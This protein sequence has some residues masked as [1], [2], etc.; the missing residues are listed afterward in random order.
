[1]SMRRW[2]LSRRDLLFMSGTLMPERDDREHTA[3]LIQEDES[4]IEAMLDDE[5]LFR[6]LMSEEE[7][8]VLISP[9]LFFTV[10]LRRARR[11]LEQEVFTV[12]RRS[13]QKVPVFDADQV[14]R[15]LEQEPLLDYLAGMLASFTRV[16]SVTVP[17]RVRRGVWRKIRISDLDVDSLM[18]YCQ[19]QDEKFHFEPYKRIADVCLFLTGMFPQYIHAQ[20]RYPLSRQLRPQVRSRM[21]RNVEDYEAYGRAF[22]RLAA[23]HERARVE[24]LD[25]VLATLSANFIL[26]EKP[27]IFLADRYLG[28]AKQRLFEL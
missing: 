28:F 22:Y 11:D 21:C 16:E 17:I 23:E 5:R 12:E 20:Y 25:D 10:L 13:R 3:D 6:R 2:R 14:I 26:A 27:L 18:R 1:M 7:I 4:F 9:W 8:L 15:L 19:T 24:G